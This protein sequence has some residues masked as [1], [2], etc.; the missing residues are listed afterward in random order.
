MGGFDW[1]QAEL[2]NEAPRAI[3]IFNAF[4]GEDTLSRRPHEIEYLRMKML[5]QTSID[6]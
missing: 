4:L 6:D 3:M 5:L 2:N 1:V